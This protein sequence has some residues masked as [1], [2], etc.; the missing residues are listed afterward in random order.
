MYN[1]MLP[2]SFNINLYLYM[3]IS[4]PKMSSDGGNWNAV[5]NGRTKSLI[6]HC[7]RTIWSGIRRSTRKMKSEKKRRDEI[8]PQSSSSDEKNSEPTK[9]REPLKLKKRKERPSLVDNLFL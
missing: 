6:E 7:K 5:L 4:T 9:N 2:E 3:E 1:Y 8:V